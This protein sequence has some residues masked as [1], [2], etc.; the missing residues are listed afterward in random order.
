MR[1]QLFSRTVVLLVLGTPTLFAAEKRIQAK[2]LPPAVQAAVQDATRGA[3]IKGYAREVGGGKTMFEVETTVNGHARD[4]L[5]DASGTLVEVEEAMSLDAVPVA[6]KTAL[7]ARGHV[8]TVEQVTR[9]KAITY[10]A[11]VEHN[12]KQSEVAVTADGKP[13]KS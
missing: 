8:V 13:I 1:M 6:V 7:A 2:D 3:T 4:L 12:G 5:F 9:G 10:E 11:V